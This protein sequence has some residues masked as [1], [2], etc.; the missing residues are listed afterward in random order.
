MTSAHKYTAHLSALLFVLA[1]SS[2]AVWA[3]SVSYTITGTLTK[4]GGPDDLMLN[5]KSVT[6]TATL[7]QTTVPTSVATATS[8]TNTYTNVSGVQ[9]TAQGF[10]TLTCSA[11]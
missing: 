2:S 1:A 7:S 11:A 4:T 8:V 9:L 10:P 6:A 3:Q 5:G